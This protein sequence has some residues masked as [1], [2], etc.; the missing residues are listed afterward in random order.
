[1]AVY[2]QIKQLRVTAHPLHR[3]NIDVVQRGAVAALA[4][5]DLRTPVAADGTLLKGH[6]SADGLPAVP[7]TALPA[8]GRVTGGNAAVAL[9]VVAAAPPAMRRHLDRIDVGPDGLEAQLRDGPRVLLGTG[10]RPRAKWIATG[11]VLGDPN[12]AGA[13][14]IDVRLPER[15]A[16]GGFGDEVQPSG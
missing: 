6:A 5:G 12:S 9:A 16:A 11:R 15:P 7:A 1:V 13:D 14:Y 3:L 2:P 10:E 4:V 8:G